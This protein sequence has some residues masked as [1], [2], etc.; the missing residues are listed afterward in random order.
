MRNS[1][2]ELGRRD[3][4]KR[5][6]R[7]RVAWRM[8]VG[9]ARPSPSLPSPQPGNNT[10]RRRSAC[11]VPTSC[12]S[13]PVET[14]RAR[15][16]FLTSGRSDGGAPARSQRERG[17]PSL[18]RPP[19]FPRNGALPLPPRPGAP[20]TPP[21]SAGPVGAREAGGR[22]RPPPAPPPPPPAPLTPCRPGPGHE[23]SQLRPSV[24]AA[25]AIAMAQ[26]EKMELDLE[27]P[28][29]GSD[30]G[31]LRRSNSAPL[32]HG[33]SD[34]SQVFQPHVLR[35][36]R[37]STTV[38][39]RHSMLIS[40]S[41]V[42]IPSSRLHQIRR[43]EGVDLMNRETAHEREVQ[44]AMQISQSWEES[45][46]LSDNDLDK[47]EK[48]SSPKR[49]DFIPVSPAPSPTRGIGKQ[50]FSPSLQMFVSSNGLPPSP[51]PSPT[52]RFSKRSQS[53]INCIRPSV[54][55]P[56]KRKGEMETESQPK[57]LFQG[58]TTMLSPDVTH[59]TDLSSCLSS[60]IL[61]GSTS[62]VSSSSDSLAKGSTTTESPVACSN[63][64]SS[65]ILMDDLSPK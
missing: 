11:V 63:S 46:S 28:P 12:L 41:P 48:S 26:A 38:M 35:T 1:H 36:R 17:S 27:L 62:S 55:G 13:Q 4:A 51:I 23:E 54:L 21:A 9:A 34:N 16:S 31:G 64:C 40:S 47:S 6:A 49:I 14:L 19:Q 52:R 24:S 30:G 5:D 44:T 29:A 45:L 57:R 33:L 59:L 42:R 2:R 39:N 15:L 37:N 60:D 25:A 10:R 18:P 50:C 65:F 58:T 43:E 7:T 56:I 53:P 3:R 22:Q 61:D 32:I 8:R 20:R